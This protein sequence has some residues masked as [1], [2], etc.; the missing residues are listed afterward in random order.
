[1]VLFSYKNKYGKANLISFYEFLEVIFEKL[2][3]QVTTVSAYC[4]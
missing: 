3:C 1:M 4:N 2:P